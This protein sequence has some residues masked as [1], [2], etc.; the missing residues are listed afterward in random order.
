MTQSQKLLRIL[1]LYAQEKKDSDIKV[2]DSTEL[3]HSLWLKV[4]ISQN[5]TEA[6]ESQFT[7]KTFRIKISS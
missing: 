1:E 6:V 5:I 4:A 2:Q 3:S 7:A